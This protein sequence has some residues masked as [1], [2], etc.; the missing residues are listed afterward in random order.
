M[1]QSENQEAIDHLLEQ[2]ERLLTAWEVD[3]L[4]NID[5]HISL[6]RGQQE[7]LDRIWRTVVVER[8]RG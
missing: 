6:S 1:S 2:Q 7:T 3:F 8:R 4:N 5:G